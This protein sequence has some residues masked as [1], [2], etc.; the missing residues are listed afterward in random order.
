M[1]RPSLRRI[2]RIASYSL[3]T[4]SVLYIVLLYFP[5]PLFAYSE[6]Y[7]SFEIYSDRPIDDDLHKVLDRAEI[8]LKDSPIYD[9]NVERRVFLTGS[10]AKYGFLANKAYRSFGSTIPF[11][12]NVMINKSD[13]GIDLVL[14]P[15]EYSDRRSLSGVV[16]HE[17]T[18]LLV[19]RRY[20]TISSITMP[21]W[22]VEGYCEYI[23]RESTIP[24][25]EGMRRWREN[26]GDDSGYRYTKYHAMVKYML[27]RRGLT[28]DDLFTSKLN[29]TE[30][31]AETLAEF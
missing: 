3:A 11:L 28:V 2:Y 25:D 26:P 13:A 1:K 9:A 16:A 21:T 19:R 17:I 20:G 22:K 5:Q 15:R 23:A 18:H 7:E 29:E 27:E 6:R 12:D 10:F 30:V 4:I 31:A 8:L 24:L 14:M